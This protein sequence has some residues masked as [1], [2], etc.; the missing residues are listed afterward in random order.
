[1]SAPREPVAIVGIG[2]RFP[3]ASSP[4]AFW[5][6]LID[7]RCTVGEVPRDRF[8]LDLYYDP[9]PATPGKVSTRHGGFLENIDTLDA[10]FFGI[11]PREA[12]RLDPQ[13]RLL[14]EVGFEA[15][16]DAGL[17]AFSLGGSPTGVFV[18]MWLNDFEGRL[19]SDPAGPDFYMTTGSGRYSASG[20]VSYA[21]GLQGPSLTIDAACASSLAAVHLACQSLWS[22][23]AKLALA[24]GSNVILQ[25][26]ISIAYS[27]SRMLAADGRCKFGDAKADGYVRSEG[28]ALV[29]LKPLS[30]ARRDGD[31]VY[32][33]I[34]GGAVNNDGRTSG[35]MTTPGRG[36]QEDMLRKAYGHAG[37]SPGQVGY[38]EAHGTGTRA[39]DPVELGALGTVLREGRPAGQTCAVGSVKTNIGH[40]EGAAGVAGLIKVALSL[41]HG[42]IPPSLHMVEPNPDIPWQELRVAIATEARPWSSV[43]GPA[44]AGVS[45][46]GISGTNAHIVLGRPEGD[47]VPAAAPLVSRPSL[48]T[49]SARTPEALVEQARRFGSWLSEEG[50]EISLEDVAHTASR[51]SPLEYRLA[52]AAESREAWAL[53]LEAHVRGESMEGM[54]TGR[55]REGEHR[56]VF[57]FP[58]QGGQWLGMGRSL[59]EREP[60]FRDAILEC[61]RAFRP[62]VDWSLVDELLA[63][64]EASRLDDIS[65][66]QPT[67]FAVQVALAALWR[68][69]GV[70]P[71]AAVGHSMGEAA[72]AFVSGALSLDAASRVICRRSELLKRISGQGTMA[73]VELSLEEASRAVAGYEDRVSVA[74]S[75]SSRSS[76]LSGDPEALD[77]I[78]A[79]LEAREVFCRRVKVDVASHSPQV[80]PLMGPLV[81]SLGDLGEGPG[82]IPLWSTVTAA[83]IVGA[84]VGP[85]YWGRNLREAVRFAATIRG[86]AASG[87]DT[88]IEM[89][90]HPVL[91]GSIQQE[92]AGEGGALAFPSLRREQD[93]QTTFLESLGAAYASGVA[94]AWDRLCPAGRVVGLPT[95]AWQRERFWLESSDLSQAG[96]RLTVRTAAKPAAVPENLDDLYEMVWR[97]APLASA[98]A[99]T[100]G[101]T[102]VLISASTPVALALENAL[103]ARGASVVSI[104]PAALASAEAWR[105]LARARWNGD[106][107][108]CAGVV[109]LDSLSAPAFADGA[110]ASLDHVSEI[111]VPALLALVQTLADGETAKPPRVYVVTAGTQAVTSQ[112]EVHSPAAGLLWGLGRVIGGEQPQLRATNIDLEVAD[113]APALSAL[114]DELL[115]DSAENQVAFRGGRRYLLRLLP[116]ASARGDRAV[117]RTRWRSARPAEGRPFRATV[118]RAGSVEGLALEEATRHAPA[119]GQ[120]EIEVVASGLNFMN[121]LSVLGVYPGALGGVGPLG[122][123]ATGRVA[124]VGEGVSGLRPGDPVMA[125]ALDSLATH[126]HTDR[127]LVVPLPSGL[128]FEQAATL[129][130][131]FLTAL[132]ALDSLARLCSGETVLIHAA[133]GG[134]G[135]AALQVARARGARV[136]ASAG[137]PEK[138]EWLRSL[139]VEHI[140]DSRSLDFGD[141]VLAA[142]GGRGVD[143]VLNSLAGEF[144]DRGLAV[145]APGGRF[146]E[147]G[148]RDIHEGRSLDLS[149][150]RKGI[151]FFAVDLER[152]IREAPEAVGR[153]LAEIREGVEQGIWRPLQHRAFPASRTREGLLTLARGAA[154]RQAGRSPRR[155]GGRDRGARLR[156]SR[157]P[158]GHLPGH[159]RARRSRPRERP[160]PGGRRSAP[161][162]ARRAPAS[163][164]RGHEPDRSPARHRGRG[165]GHGGRPGLP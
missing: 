47:A 30:A 85:R 112:G 83:E 109:A 56:V 81:M 133:T 153:S 48:L 124:A 130:I 68:S 50:R 21:F 165:A 79:V 46:F 59:L 134:V 58:G 44:L 37:I 162:R 128:D 19:F 114:C 43:D 108:R 40:T 1:M 90:P 92:L 160:L 13:Q 73:V 41:H 61:E 118:R 110:A 147:L 5:R 157:A 117:A 111:C 39:G 144:V 137:S 25:P 119:P 135:L 62:Y 150:F 10:D 9:R 35:F 91:V 45:S 65:V 161:S 28:A 107:S 16:E 102:W 36:G 55:A 149:L 20:R 32:A 89:G 49:L 115:S 125:V 82:R 139:G 100:D 97:E 87:Y 116:H 148:K 60:A 70:E 126:A 158:R 101:R 17:S 129:P 155:P 88:F 14:L 72:A 8:D 27:Q 34:L 11:S 51:R 140:V 2:C 103:A 104:A 67:L 71:A 156:S 18:G 120:V 42:I 132:H 113:A 141:A 123:E 53:R 93:E 76:V 12:E 86:L 94:V 80:E 4:A 105:E 69:L 164:R 127:R 75:N 57:V 159:G 145:L 122:G 138:R 29:A 77:R 98:P 23:E 64:P 106:W 154:S 96:P 146:I 63:Q 38:V 22:G 3:G 31:R 33:V 121:A 24:G 84:D 26:H 142:T 6:L 52:V 15:L 151:G 74:V 143:V 99:S 66:V 95:Y 7:G 136:V 131:A 152:M 163:D 54:A 78:L